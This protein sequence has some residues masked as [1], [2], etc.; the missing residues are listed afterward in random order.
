MVVSTRQF[1]NLGVRLLLE[2]YGSYLFRDKAR[3]IMLFNQVKLQPYGF[4]NW[5]KVLSKSCSLYKEVDELCL[6]CSPLITMKEPTEAD[7]R[8]F[9]NSVASVYNTVS[10]CGD[11]NDSDREFL[12]KALIAIPVIDGYLY[13]DNK[14][15]YQK[16][17]TSMDIQKDTWETLVYDVREF[18]ADL[19]YWCELTSS[20]TAL[21][22][23]GVT[24]QDLL[25]AL[26]FSKEEGLCFFI[27]KIK[28][29][30]SI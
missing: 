19:V 1:R 28:K 24:H 14:D 26:I 10:E 13:G 5:Y 15:D 29:E 22:E 20:D 17:V 23:S 18:T 7:K 12:E 11:L 16:I 4:L 21:K 3:L 27:E 6:R 8:K 25:E 9:R 30:R 2:K